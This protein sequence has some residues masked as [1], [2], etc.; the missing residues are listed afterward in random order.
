MNM[1]D[2]AIIG[3]GPA[4]GTAAIYAARKK[5]KT[6]LITKDFGGQSTVTPEIQNWLGIKS[7]SG[8]KFGKMIKEHVESYSGRSL[9]IKTGES[10]TSIEEKEG[11]LIKS[12]KEEYSAY[13][14]L[15]C[16]GGQRRR[17]LVKGAEEFENKGITYCAT[18]D[19]PMFAD[20]DVAVI[21][22]GNSGFE[23]A[24]QLIPYAKTITIIHKNEN[25]RADPITVEEVTKDQKVKTIKNAELKEITGD[26]MVNGL[27]YKDKDT[28]KE[29]KL[30]LT[31][32]FV[33]IG[34]IP[35]TEFV[36]DLVELDQNGY[37]NV[38][39]KNQR[40]SHNR[41]WAAGDCINYPYRQNLIAA[42][43]GAAAV[44]DIYNKIKLG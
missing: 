2:L 17:L 7:I 23:T 15:V 26:K 27:I 20:Q 24:M 40:T 25:F 44:E 30:E 9:V 8:I 10:I 14:I 34:M 28:D 22:G 4:G 39:H 31:G 21:G 12:Q 33:E 13:S 35:S 1:Y 41:I 29:H 42:G 18:C 32:I 43:M 36:K 3:G 5:L 37:I 11:F 38:D 6:V 16:S 19:A